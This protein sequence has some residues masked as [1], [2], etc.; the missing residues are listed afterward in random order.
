MTNELLSISKHWAIDPDA[1]ANLNIRIADYRS[2][3]FM[4]GSKEHNPDIVSGVAVIPVY[5]V[6]TARFDLY[7]TIFGGTAL[8]QIRAALENAIADTNVTSILLD[9]D[10]P[11]GV[12]VGPSELSE[13][14]KASP[15]PIF[16]YV[17]RN[18]C[19]AAY[20]IASA[21]T[22]IIAHKSAILGS[23][24]VVST[25]AVQETPDAD[26]NRYIEIVSSNAKDKRPDPRTPEG[27]GT[28]RAELDALEFEFISAVAENRKLPVDFIKAEFGQG[29]VK[30]GRDAVSCGM[31]DEQG[32]YEATINQL[33][34]KKMP[35]EKPTISAEQIAEY[36][37]E[38]AA[39]ERERL[40]ALDE[41]AMVGY[42]DLL[43]AAKADPSKTAS[44]LAL[45]I[46]QAEKNKG[47][48]HIASLKAADAAMP[49][50]AP[51]QPKAE[52]IFAN[53]TE[54]A[55]HEWNMSAEIRSEFGGNKDAYIAFKVAE[56]NGQIK[57][58]TKGK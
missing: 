28:I 5:G 47:N 39:A 8:T 58:Q 11:G 55:E 53:A 7:T 6:I 40:N 26:G 43:K 10:S 19:S 33:K 56:E 48:S 13:F 51:S 2:G 50:V 57:I 27:L 37:A 18:C 12:A 35:E 46:V 31:A 49:I 1:L 34:G 45:Q 44:S 9:I 24:G 3:K 32:N 25:V 16:A 42:E 54:R 52:P 23:I 4:P 21:C 20:W 38:G 36:R 41:V 15:K 30:I 17:G 14:I 22:K 29:G